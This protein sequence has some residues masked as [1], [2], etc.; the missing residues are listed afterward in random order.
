VPVMGG[1]IS[2]IHDHLSPW[3][4]VIC[5]VSTIIVGITSPYIL[6]EVEGQP[7]PEEKEHYKATPRRRIATVIFGVA[8]PACR[9][10]AT[11]DLT[12]SFMRTC[13]FQFYP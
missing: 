7:T 3:W 2:L 12:R 5:G 1:I 9:N 13:A 11:D 10:R 8:A 6:N 4:L